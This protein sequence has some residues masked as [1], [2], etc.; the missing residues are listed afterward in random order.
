MKQ[1][2]WHKEIKA[3]AKDESIEYYVV[4]PSQYLY[5]YQ[6]KETKCIPFML[7]E[8]TDKLNDEY[9]YLGKI[10]LEDEE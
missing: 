7:L 6:H 10:K 4:P 2:K 1:H 5:L 9:N 8:K 3:W